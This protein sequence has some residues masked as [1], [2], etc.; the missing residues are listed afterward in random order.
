MN[1]IAAFPA[2]FV[3]VGACA[4]QAAPQSSPAPPASEVLALA[5]AT[6]VK[7]HKPVFVHFGASW[8]SSCRQL[9]AFLARP[10]VQAIF[11]RRFVVTRLDVLESGGNARQ[12]NLGG[13][14]LLDSL[15]P[16]NTPLPYYAILDH[17]GK[18]IVTGNRPSSRADATTI[19][20]PLA[21]GS[22][23]VF[24]RFLKEGNPS[25]PDGELWTLR[26][27]LERWSPSGNAQP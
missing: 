14:Q 2:A 24:L 12:E 8:C 7:Q 9:D 5:F 22:I 27:E 20:F 26:G 6:S 3:L 4:T 25:I 18:P 23:G 15:G 16:P 17:A 21:Y 11:S 13:K 19:A 1:K 10:P